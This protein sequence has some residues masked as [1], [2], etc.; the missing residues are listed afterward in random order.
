MSLAEMLPNIH[1]LSRL[2]K[3]RLIEVLA[4]DLAEGEEPLIPPNRSYPVWSP[5]EA[6][7]AAETMLRF[8]GAEKE[9]S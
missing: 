3:L 8:L 4:H 5:S 2:D 9:K 1:A 6:F 7:G